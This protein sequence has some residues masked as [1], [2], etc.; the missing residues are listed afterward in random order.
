MRASQVTS[1]RTRCC[2]SIDFTM[3]WMFERRASSAPGP[4]EITSS[5]TRSAYARRDRVH[6]V[7]AAGAVGHADHAEPAGRA[8]VAVGREADRGLVR[9]ASPS[10]SRCRARGS[11]TG[12]A[13]D[14]P[15][16]RRCASRPG[17]AG[18][19]PRT[20][21]AACAPSPRAPP[22]VELEPVE[23]RD[24]QRRADPALARAP[25]GAPR[26]A[27]ARPPSPRCGRSGSPPRA[28]TPRA[29]VGLGAVPE[30]RRV[31]VHDT[32]PRHRLPRAVA[33]L[34]EQ[35]ARGGL[36]AASRRDRRSRPGSRASP[37]P[38]RAGTGAPSRARRVG[39]R[40]RCSPSRRSRS[41]RMGAARRCAAS[42]R[43]VR[44][45]VKTRQS[46]RSSALDLCPGHRL[47]HAASI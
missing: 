13:R 14:R 1:D 27:R 47:G 11:G 31:R 4:P 12:R 15:G 3:W 8:R 17:A 33:G 7:V 19:R 36:A 20:R 45:T 34:L 30:Q 44:L 39:Q 25:R 18:R 22:L 28:R 5:G 24:H 41:G 16:G 42:A 46:C 37:R 29:S 23:R 21:R 35:L 32:E 26:A 38:R 2:E 9:E 6:D 43:C 10:R 40:R